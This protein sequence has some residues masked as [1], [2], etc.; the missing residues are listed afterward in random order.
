MEINFNFVNFK[1]RDF[2]PLIDRV[3]AGVLSL[4]RRPVNHEKNGIL[5]SSK[6]RAKE[7]KIFS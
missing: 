2:S 1:T 7:E 3:L 6:K 4:L 5:N